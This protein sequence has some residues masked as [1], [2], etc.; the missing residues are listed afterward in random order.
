LRG[1]LRLGLPERP[2]LLSTSPARERQDR[3][4]SLSVS[5]LYRPAVDKGVALGT[6]EVV[7]GGN[8][9]GVVNATNVEIENRTKRTDESGCT[10]GAD[11]LR[12]HG[13]RG[14]HLRTRPAV[15][16]LFEQPMHEFGGIVD[17]G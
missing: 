12:R 1:E 2:L 6:P 5:H 11:R 7:E 8:E 4:G 17:I 9:L 14:E 10:T 15:R 3:G 16:A 13:D